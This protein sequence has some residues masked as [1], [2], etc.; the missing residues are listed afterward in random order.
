MKS[1]LASAIFFCAGQAVAVESWP[2]WEI[3]RVATKT[4]FWLNTV[5][6]DAPDQGKY[7]GF[8]SVKKNYY[9]CY[10]DG[11]I[12]DF[13]W[14]NKSSEEMRSRSTKFKRTGN[15]LTVIT[16]IKTENFLKGE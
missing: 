5:P 10:F 4:Y 16:D 13:K 8:Q 11:D 15:R 2:D 9:T 6:V 14:T 12:A 1:I 7:M 3:C